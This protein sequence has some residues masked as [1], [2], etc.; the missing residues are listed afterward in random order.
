MVTVYRCP[1]RALPRVLG[2]R[3]TLPLRRARVLR[4]VGKLF[5]SAYRPG[6]SSTLFAT[7]PN[8]SH[9]VN[10]LLAPSKMLQMAAPVPPGSAREAFRRLATLA[11]CVCWRVRLPRA[12]PRVR[13][14]RVLICVRVC[15]CVRAPGIS[16]CIVGSTRACALGVE[17]TCLCVN[18]VPSGPPTH[19]NPH[20]CGQLA[21]RTCTHARATAGTRHRTAARGPRFKCAARPSGSCPR[22]CA[23][24]ACTCAGQGTHPRIPGPIREWGA[25]TRCWS[26]TTTAT[27]RSASTRTCRGRQRG[28]RLPCRSL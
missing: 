21:P 15:A 19:T 5:F 27:T 26:C 14:D 8:D 28:A 13:F 9:A 11:R 1:A 23:A 6:A 16:A 3:L 22:P 17:S 4:D 7:L 2:P 18:C 24:A 20:D 10:A 12:R 25:G